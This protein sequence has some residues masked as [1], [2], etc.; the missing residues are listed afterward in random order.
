MKTAKIT[1]IETLIVETKSALT[2][3]AVKHELSIGKGTT[4]RTTEIAFIHIDKTQDFN[5][6]AL[7]DWLINEGH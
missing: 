7:Q 1:K 2:A 4:T 6:L 5:D 3:S